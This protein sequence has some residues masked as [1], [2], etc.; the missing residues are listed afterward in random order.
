[1]NKL[2]SIKYLTQN[3]GYWQYE[4]RV[5]K[6]FLEHPYWQ[7]K[8]KWKQPLGLK[9][10]SYVAEVIAVWKEAHSTFEKAIGNIRRR[11]SHSH[12]HGKQERGDKAILHLKMFGL[13]PH[14]GSLGDASDRNERSLKIVAIE[15]IRKF[16]GAFDDYIHW[17][18]IHHGKSRKVGGGLLPRITMMSPKVQLQRQAWLAYTESKKI[19]QHLLFSDLWEIYT[20]GKRLSMLD[21]KNQKIQKRWESFLAVVRGEGLTNASIR[22]GLRNWLKAQIGR[23]V[24][25]QT[26]KRELG[27][28]H[29]VLNYV[30]QTKALELQ[31]A[32][33]RL[34]ITAEKKTRSHSKRN[35][36]KAIGPDPR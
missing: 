18:K 15:K 27:V 4:R 23:N 9:V 22:R 34:E 7:G 31:W 17:E 19:N 21:C 16:S 28:I 26:L 8:V 30:R 3:N 1:M 10:G 5:P 13:N 14:E 12:S 35:L 6:S 24:K 20:L 33:P 25:Y 11:N 32:M 2:K 29:A 36:S